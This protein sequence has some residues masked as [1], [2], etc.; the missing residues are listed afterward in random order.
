MRSISSGNGLNNKGYHNVC[1]IRVSKLEPR[2][3]LTDWKIF[4]YKFVEDINE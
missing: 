4:R 2:L 1:Y 3:I